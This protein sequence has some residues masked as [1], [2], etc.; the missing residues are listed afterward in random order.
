MFEEVL[1][2]TLAYA[3]EIYDKVIRRWGNIK[4]AQSS[5]YDWI[6]S[7][8]FLHFCHEMDPITQG[9]LRLLIMENFNVKP[10]PWYP[11]HN[12]DP[13]LER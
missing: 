2:H 4:F 13:T 5:V 1:Q 6:W 11:T 10:W 9:Q 3:E 12:S 8:E 7:D